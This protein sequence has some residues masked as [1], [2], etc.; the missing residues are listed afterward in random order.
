MRRQYEAAY[1]EHVT[2]ARVERE[3]LQADLDRA[4]KDIAAL[5]DQVK[6]NDEI[7]PRQAVSQF[8]EIRVAIRDVCYA[9]SLAF[10]AESIFHDITKSEILREPFLP[11]WQTAARLKLPLDELLQHRYVCIL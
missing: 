10:D 3:I 1:Q 11:L 6:L 9:I 2:K 5:R 8:D 4:Q 7:E